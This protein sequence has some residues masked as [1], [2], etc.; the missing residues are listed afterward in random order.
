MGN[1]PA[2]SRGIGPGWILAVGLLVGCPGS[3]V[4]N[5]LEVN[6]N[7][8]GPHEAFDV[9]DR[10]VGFRGLA[11]YATEDVSDEA[12]LHTAH[13]LAQYVDNDEDGS[14]DSPA[15]YDEL[16][17]L[18]AAMV[19]FDS[20]DAPD[21]DAFLAADLPADLAVQDLYG[22]EI[23]PGGGAAGEFDATLEEV[24]HLVTHSGFARVFTATFGEEPGSAIADAMDAAIVEGH[25]DPR[26]HE[27]DMPYDHQV[28]E[29][30]YWALTSILGAQ[31]HEGRAEEIEAEWSLNTAALVQEHDPVIYGLLTDPQWGHASTLPD[32]SYEAPPP[33]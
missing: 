7:P 15:V 20:P 33:S 24:L 16:W 26:V 18:S 2:V 5:D 29:Y 11:V 27:P 14:V 23:H 1:K 3:D 30:H 32:G 4:P 25:Y 13:V 22:D 8:G 28:T 21:V 9:F 19:L 10:F 12:L 17:S 6:P 31:D